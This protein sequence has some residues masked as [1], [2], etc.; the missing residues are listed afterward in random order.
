MASVQPVG[1]VQYPGA[2]LPALPSNLTQQQVRDVYQVRRHLHP[3]S[4]FMI[5]LVP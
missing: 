2:A 1:P 4:L 5:V 3:I